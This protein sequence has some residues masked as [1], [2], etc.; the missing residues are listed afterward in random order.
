MLIAVASAMLL[1]AAPPVAPTGTC[2]DLTTQLDAI[3]GGPAF[4]GS[5]F[6]IYV[7]ELDGDRQLYHAAADLPLSDLAGQHER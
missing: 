7:R 1:W 3:L 4:E 2:G 6:G 5:K